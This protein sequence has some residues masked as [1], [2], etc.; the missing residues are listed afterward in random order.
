MSMK[1]PTARDV[2]RDI[3]A[4][5]AKQ[6]QA[7]TEEAVAEAVKL[8]EKRMREAIGTCAV[9]VANYFSVERMGSELLIRVQ[10]E[11]KP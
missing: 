2:A 8:F 4:V 5:V 3:E 1:L 9:N 7:L 6:A 10:I 11:T